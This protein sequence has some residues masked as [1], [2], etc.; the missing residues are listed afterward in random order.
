MRVTKHDR[1]RYEIGSKVGG[2]DG[3]TRATGPSSDTSMEG[4]H[5]YGPELLCC[6]ASCSSLPPAGTETGT[7]SAAGGIAA[8]ARLVLANSRL[9]L[10]AA[11]ATVIVAVLFLVKRYGS[12]HPA[13]CSWHEH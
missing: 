1:L 7:G 6:R 13:R 9:H 11:V 4:M 8:A 5:G 3:V 12:R 10:L 2:G